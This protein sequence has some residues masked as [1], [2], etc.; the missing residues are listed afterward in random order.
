MSVVRFVQNFSQRR[1][2]I[3]SADARAIEAL[4][5]T[6]GKLGLLVE[7]LGAEGAQAPLAD[8][9]AA[10]D[11]LFLDGDLHAPPIVPTGPT[12]ELPLVPLVGLV[13]VEAP[14]RLRALM[15]A[16][17]TAFLPKPVY[18]GSVYS[19]L[20]L[21]V[22]EHARKAALGSAVEEL[23]QRRRQR[24]YVVKAILIVIAEAGLDD[25]A[26]FQSLRRAAMRARLGLEAYC[27]QLVRERADE[28]LDNPAA[29]FAR[30]AVD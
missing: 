14:S 25:E 30:A 21:A 23:E 9:D 4:S 29:P 28:D 27:E 3:A 24:R 12:A 2:L 26:A 1:A 5:V 7:P 11:V 20:Y 15:L 8:L 10:R 17:A 22:N 6:L 19:A 18:G 13:G 16:G